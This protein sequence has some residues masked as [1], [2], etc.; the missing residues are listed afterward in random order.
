MGLLVAH[1][2]RP[3]WRDHVHVVVLDFV[4]GYAAFRSDERLGDLRAVVRHGRV[5]EPLAQQD[6]RTR[7]EAA[8]VVPTGRGLGIEQFIP[9]T[10]HLGSRHPR[11]PLQRR[12]V[13]ELLALSRGR[14]D[15]KGPGGRSERGGQQQDTGAKMGSWR[16]EISWLGLLQNGDGE[17]VG[18]PLGGGQQM[19]FP[20][21]SR[22]GELL[23][24]D[25]SGKIDGS[26]T[27][28]KSI[29]YRKFDF[30]R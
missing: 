1:E 24:G 7:Q 3:S 30:L 6:Q 23:H 25:G 11:R 29:T 15:G 13:A 12:G 5:V 19:G 21:G 9:L 26:E 10:G 28:P 17:W 18:G 14:G 8:S 16:E 2:Q 4:G 27:R 20:S 22:Q